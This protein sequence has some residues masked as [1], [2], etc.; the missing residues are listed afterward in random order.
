E[1]NTEFAQFLADAY[2]RGSLRAVVSLARIDAEARERAAK[3]IVAATVALHPGGARGAGLRWPTGR[4]PPRLLGPDGHDGWDAL[5]AAEK[6]YRSG[7]A[8]ADSAAR[9]ER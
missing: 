4:V 9:E 3:A 2:S 8:L 1:L 5:A 7:G 6:A